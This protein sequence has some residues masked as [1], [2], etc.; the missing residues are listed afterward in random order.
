MK[1]LMFIFS[2]LKT[3]FKTEPK[4]AIRDMSVALLLM[5]SLW[6]GLWI[7]AILEGRA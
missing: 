1:D 6:A 5:L 2:E 3:Y 7:I 4:N